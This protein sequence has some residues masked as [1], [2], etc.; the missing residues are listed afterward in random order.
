MDVF[1]QEQ[2]LVIRANLLKLE[3]TELFNAHMFLLP[4]ARRVCVTGCPLQFLQLI[5]IGISEDVLVMVYLTQVD[6]CI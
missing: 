1:V 2:F 6:I 5:V 3:F 4:R